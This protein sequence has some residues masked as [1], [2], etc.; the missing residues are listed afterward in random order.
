M[1]ELCAGTFGRREQAQGSELIGHGGR[2]GEVFLLGM[3]YGAASLSVLLFGGILLYVF[4]KGFRTLDLAFL[5]GVGSV[6][7]DRVG[8][9]GNLVNT[10]YIIVI[11]LLIAVPVGVGGAVYLNE[12]AEPGRVT[13]LV[14]FATETLSGIPSVVFGLFGSVFFGGLGLEYSLLRGALT[15]SLMVLPLIVRNTQ[16]ALRTVPEG[17]RSA[18]LGLGAT[19]WDMIRTVLLPWARPGILTGLVLAAGRIVGESAALLLTAGSAGLL[20]GQGNGLLKGLAERLLQSGGTLTVEL[21][22]QMQNGRYE[23][24]FGIGCVLLLILFG[25]N[26]LLRLAVRERK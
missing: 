10:L 6:L 11:A 13:E 7:Q 21:Y 14:E 1:S 4:G 26:L 2:P 5:T 17:L 9:A 19:R 3:I 16:E 25:I 8:I 15:V 22:L 20:P 24:A 12:Y 23:T 18:S